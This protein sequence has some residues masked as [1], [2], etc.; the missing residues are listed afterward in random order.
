MNS[1]SKLASCAAGTLL[2]FANSGTWAQQEETESA[3]GSSI[4]TANKFDWRD[5]IEWAGDLRI[6]FESIERGSEDVRHRSRIR[7][8]LGF[9]LQASENV[10]VGVRI[11]TGNGSPVSTNVNFDD[12]FSLKQIGLDRAYVDWHASENLDFVVGKMK[13]PWFRAG[14]NS[15]QWD[16]DMNPEGIAAKYSATNGGFFGSLGA[17]SVAE[18]S[19]GNDSLLVSVQGGLLLDIGD[20][21]Q[22]TTSLSYFGYTNTVGNQ[23][24]YL[25]RARGNSVDGN[26]DFLYE[27][28][29]AELGAELK[30]ALSGLPVTAFAVFAR[31]TQVSNEDTAYA[32]G[33]RLADLTA[34]ENLQLSYAWHA[35]DADALI[36]I[37]SDSDFAGGD[38]NSSGHFIKARYALMDNIE[39]GATL[40]LS[41]TLESTTSPVEYKRLQL[42]IEV[43]FE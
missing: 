23:P 39:L 2:A 43:S 17:F 6:R 1:W 4:A 26:G 22:L 15:L 18:R 14:N 32:I 12:G 34:K 30:T 29:V 38:T 27:Y 25:G 3:I 21:S 31:N 10:D 9:V 33:F 16:S 13:T 7:G 37:F 42:D 20:D 5:T 35:T 36:G 40:I 41:D 19:G 28:G 11:A 24:F 8:R